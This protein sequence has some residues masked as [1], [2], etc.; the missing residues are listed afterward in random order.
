MKIAVCIPSRGTI[1]S[2][3]VEE[4]LREVKGFDYQIFWSHANPI[5]DCFNIITKQALADK[6]VTHLWFVEEDMVLPKGILRHQV[7]EMTDKHAVA[8]AAD[9]PLVQAPSATVY[10]DPYGYAY[11]SGCGSLLV[12]RSV[13]TKEPY[14]RADIQWHIE[15]KDDILEIAPK[16]ADAGK[17]YGQQDISFGVSLYLK[18]TPILVSS[19]TCGQ[20]TI[21]KVGGKD[22][23]AG[24]HQI[25]EYNKISE[26]KTFKPEVTN[27]IEVV[28]DGEIMNVTKEQLP[29]FL[30]AGWEKRKYG[31]LVLIDPEGVWEQI[32]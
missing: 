23:N 21:E 17:V 4:V 8:V 16:W 15:I 20:R 30:E 6:E 22:N 10:R 26:K 32:K 12:K 18:G 5:P 11:F 13:F 7:W 3:T 28:K 24:F 29:R 9:Y 27:F 14:W 25:V 1:Y 19:M 31:E 2:Q